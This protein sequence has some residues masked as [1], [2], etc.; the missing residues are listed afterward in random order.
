MKWERREQKKQAER[1]R[2]NK[3]GSTL[4]RLLE[5][6]RNRKAKI[7]ANNSSH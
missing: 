2:M 5:F 6:F 4:K 3:S 7:D 1:D